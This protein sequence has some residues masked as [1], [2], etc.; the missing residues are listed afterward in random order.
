MRI[1]IATDAA[2]PQ[3]NGVVRTYERLAAELE[4]QSIETVFLT[5][6]DFTTVALPFYREIRVALPSMRHARRRIDDLAPDFI[7][8]A[9]EGPVG[10][11]A[12]RVCLSRGQPFTTSYHTKFPEYASAH[13][14]LPADWCYGP[15]RLFH[16]AGAGTMVATASLSRDLAGRGFKHLLPW[17]RGVDTDLF[18]P[19]DVRLFGSDQPVFLYVG[20]VSREKNIEAFL[21][22]ELPG[23]KVVVGGGPHLA[24][25]ARAYPAAHFTGPKTGVDLAKAYASGD[26]FVFPSRTDTFGLVLLE[27]MASGLP[28]AAYPV[29][30][31]IDLVA[32]GRTGYLDDDLA[33]AARKALALDRTAARRHACQFSWRRMAD[34]FVEN[35]ERALL[36]GGPVKAPRRTVLRRVRKLRSI[37]VQSLQR[38]RFR[39]L[40]PA[41]I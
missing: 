17:T 38:P 39:R 14:G 3:V 23:R 16:N 9:T 21:G 10:W 29:T 20:R 2:P 32:N 22:A 15:A 37:G 5:P 33:V 4:A 8:V 18:R 30:G 26:V 13:L 36:R 31:P 25:L 24:E 19:R 34:Q 27:A 7:H 6:A 41:K 35:V 12:R 40:R 1:L 11:M 28:I